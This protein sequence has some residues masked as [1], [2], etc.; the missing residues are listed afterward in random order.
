MDV[1]HERFF[2]YNQSVDFREIQE[3]LVL[4]E[5]VETPGLR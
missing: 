1:A 5:R 3:V 2:V 4:R